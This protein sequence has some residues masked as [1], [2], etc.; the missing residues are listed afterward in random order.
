MKLGLRGRLIFI[1]MI[2]ICLGIAQTSYAQGLTGQISGIIVDSSKGV[3]PG[4][5]V[6]VRNTS[7]QVTRDVVTDASGTFVVTNLLAGTYDL[8]AKL[9]GFKTYEQ[10]GVALTATERLALPAITLDVGGLEETVT[11]QADSERIQT[12]SG[13]RSAVIRAND[14]EDRGL[15]GRDPLGTLMTLPGVIDTSNREAPGSTGGLSI[16]GQT[17]IAFA[18]DGITSKDTGSNGGNFARPALDS[19]AEIKLQASNFQAEYGRSSGATIVVVTK[20]GSRDFR[21]SLAYFRRDDLFNSNSW[22]RKR[23]CAAGQTGSCAPPPYKYNNGTYTLGGPVILPKVNRNRDKLFFFWSHDMLPRTDPGTLSQVNMPTP[24]ERL[25]D[26]SETR[27]SQ[28]RLVFIRDPQLNLPCNVTTG[29]GGGCFSGNVIPSFRINPLAAV[30][31]NANLLPLPNT[32][33]PTGR[34]Q[35]NY[36]F[37]NF[38]EQ[39]RY[40]HTAR[41]D[42]NISN[43][44]TFYSR[45]QAGTNTVQQGYSA[46][47]GASGNGGWPQYYSSRHDTTESMVNT[48]LHTFTPA[49]VMELTFGINWADQN[50]FPINPDGG[51]DSLGSL[52]RN[53]RSAMP[54][55]PRLF[56]GSA[57][58]FDMMPN[59]S[60]AGTNALANTPDY[61]LENRY[62]FTARDDI[63]NLN[64]NFTWLKGS[65]NMKA[66]MFLE[67]MQRPASRA[68][69][70][71]GSFSFNASTENPLDANFGLAN[72][73]LGN[74][75]SYTESNLHPYAQGRYRQFEF[76]AQDNWRLKNS[77]TLDYGLRLYYIGPTFVAGQDIA[78]FDPSAYNPGRAA[79]LYQATCA[80]GA[81]TCTGANRVAANPAGGTLPAFFIGKV[82]P[83]SGD[84]TNGMVI[85][86]QTP[87]KGVFRP[88]P[89]IGFAWDVTGDGKTAVRGGAGV[90]YDR[91]GDDTVLRLIEP[92]PLVTTRTYNFVNIGELATAAPVNSLLGNA[93]AFTQ[94]FTP[95]TV[96]NWSIGVQRELPWKLTG[97]IAYVG[98][99]GRDTSAN[100][101]SNGLDYGTRRIDLNP[102]AADPTRGGTQAKDDFFFRPYVG[103]GGIQEQVWKGYNSY[104]S[105]QVSVNRRLSKGLAWGL[106]YTGSTRRSLNTFNPFL[107][108]AENTARN[109]SRNGSRPHNLVINYNYR[110]P[111]LSKVWDN[112]FVR[113]IADGWQVTGVSTFQGGTYGGFSFGF[114]PNLADDRTTGGPG[115]TRV[116]VVCDPNL[117]RGERTVDRQFRTECVQMPGPTTAANALGGFLLD[118]TDMFYLGNALGDEWLGLGYV[119]HDLSLF[120]NFA[121]GGRR[122]LQ[123]RI[124][125]YN[126]FNSVQWSGVDTS[127][128]FNPTTGAQTDAAFGTVTSTRGG[129]ARVIQLGVRFIF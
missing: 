40:D 122:N 8:T 34:N 73:L 39:P 74:L 127:A 3:M 16:N 71:N 46:S 101:D 69:S 119:N 107:S 84:L 31:L 94:A 100:Y 92:E 111:G 35:Y 51:L 37:Q 27:D 18:Y 41:V 10:K 52:A 77:F 87:F 56:D 21:G 126:L 60:W 2:A 47:L 42:W 98:N 25:G 95:P 75:N 124:E 115:G 58:P 4:V 104:H 29:V 15:K 48:L 83:G 110:I 121:F 88:A 28:G 70:F 43:S 45:F 106:S 44:T 22:E 90:F 24:K 26:F 114:S 103:Y 55:L 97:D 93:R 66:G 12:R 54:G 80:N 33:D 6:T 129:S 9:S 68:S 59:I 57:N 85:K 63:H 128:T 91:Y 49:L 116:T 17:S 64:T 36:T 23:D 102:S 72:L 117:P 79:R 120:K 50:T 32:T 112:A 14:L 108:E 96:Y 123:V 62:P 20:S 13:E 99:T 125:V 19:I 1:A 81:T 53:Q 61:R 89:R 11:V 118:P 105:I 76:F 109:E 113:G 86:Q 67:F 82:I 65:H 38:S 30:M 5:T 78:V 7:T